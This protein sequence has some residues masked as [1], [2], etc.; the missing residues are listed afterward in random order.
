MQKADKAY[1]S[2]V[3]TKALCKCD[4]LTLSEGHRTLCPISVTRNHPQQKVYKNRY[5]T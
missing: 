3:L 2:V 5:G 4:G 1:G